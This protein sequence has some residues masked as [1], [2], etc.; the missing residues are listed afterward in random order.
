MDD[1][2]Q[3]ILKAQKAQRNKQKKQRKKQRK[4]VASLET[5]G[6]SIHV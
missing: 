1:I 5:P 6:I 3:S 4:A 2:Q